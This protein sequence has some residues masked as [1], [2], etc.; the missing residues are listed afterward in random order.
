MNKK[1]FCISG[2]LLLIVMFTFPVLA[3]PATKIEGVTLSIDRTTSNDWRVVDE[4]IWQLFDGTGVGTVT[5]SIPEKGDLTGEYEAEWHGKI[6]SGPMIG[7]MQWPE[8]ECLYNRRIVLS[9]TGEG[10][11][12]TFEGTGHTKAIGF[13]PQVCS[14]MAVTMVFHGTGDFQ[15]QTLKLSFEG[16][17]PLALE[18]SI[19]MPK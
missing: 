14:Y 12:G 4:D 3:A 16:A 8:A 2:C 15:G 1:I 17:P 10:T 6:K 7:M 13:P 9:F 11:T 5:L 19:L 18:G